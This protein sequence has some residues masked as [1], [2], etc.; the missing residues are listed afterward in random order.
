MVTSRGTMLH[1]QIMW[2][3]SSGL[4][5]IIQMAIIFDP[6]IDALFSLFF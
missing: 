4:T 3:F 6:V 1:D 2:Y 5:K